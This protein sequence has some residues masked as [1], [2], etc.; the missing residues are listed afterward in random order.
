MPC[1][2]IEFIIQHFNKCDVNYVTDACNIFLSM[3]MSKQWQ[4]IEFTMLDL[5]T[6]QLI[7]LQSSLHVYLLKS[8]LGV[9]LLKK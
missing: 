3:S 7:S 1:W 2:S 9:Y 4:N 5:N 6:R 8:N